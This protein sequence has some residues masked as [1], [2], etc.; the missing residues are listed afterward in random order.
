MKKKNEKKMKIFDFQPKFSTKIQNFDFH[1]FSIWFYKG[2]FWKYGFRK[3]KIF[4]FFKKIKISKISNVDFGIFVFVWS[5]KN[6]IF[7]ET[8]GNEDVKIFNRD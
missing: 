1:D 5:E 2:F 6:L 8:G 7:D 4:D 3:S